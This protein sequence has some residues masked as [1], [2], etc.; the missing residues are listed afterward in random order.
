LAYAG[1]AA[2]YSVLG[3][4]YLPPN[5][6]YPKAKAYAAKALE[7]DDTISEAHMTMGAVRLLYDWDWAEAE[8]E[9]KRAQTL[10]PNYALAHQLDGYYLEAM[11]RVD[12]AQAEMKRALELDPLSLITNADAGYSFYFARQYDQSG[13]QCQ[14]TINLDPHFFVAYSCLGQAYEQKK[15][16]PQAIETFQK[17][18][19]LAGR[20]PELV[21]SLGHAYAL[22]GERDKANQALAE[23]RE[24]SKR[25]Y[26][27]PY[28]LA[29]VYA[30]LGDKDQT[31]AWLDKAYQDRSFFLIWLKV[32]PLFDSLRDDSRFQDLLRRVGLPQ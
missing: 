9:F 2:A 25:R 11:G 12:E 3:N 1:L 21:A 23:L 30:G 4:A 29:V 7:I 15:M 16:Y 32:E 8:K 22:S 27:S 14:K 20:H 19:N 18:M 6:A 10:N 17:G 5:E 26:V 24:L 31:F 28:S 13:A